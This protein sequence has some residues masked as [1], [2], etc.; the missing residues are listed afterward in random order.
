[1]PARAPPGDWSGPDDASRGPQERPELVV[2][3]VPASLLI[4]GHDEQVGG[5]EVVEHCPGFLDAGDGRAQLG[6]EGVEHRRLDEELDELGW[7]AGQH[8]AHQEVADGAIGAG[9]RLQEL[10]M[11]D[12]PLQGDGRQLRA[13]RPSLREL[14]QAAQLVA[15]QADV[16]Q[17]EELGQLIRGE[18]EI[19][20][21]AARAGRRAGAA[22]PATL[23]DRT[24]YRRRNGS[25]RATP[26]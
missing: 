14:V 26:R 3:A 17:R 23:A 12:P 7:Q 9:E 1:M 11:L 10:L 2:V 15:G 21:H 13:C 22:G 16:V 4:Q 25:R 20:G 5:E 24:G 19:V 8:F 6:V 18:A